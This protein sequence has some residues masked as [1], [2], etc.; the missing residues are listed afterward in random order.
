M[1][2][3]IAEI[4]MF[5]DRYVLCIF[6]TIYIYYKYVPV[7]WLTISVSPLYINA[8]KDKKL[9]STGCL[10]YFSLNKQNVYV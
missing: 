6:S 8:I 5:I 1:R 10:D 9:S 2:N 4:G 3:I 7:N